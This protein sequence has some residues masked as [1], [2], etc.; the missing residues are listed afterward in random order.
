M[1][2]VLPYMHEREGKQSYQ[3]GKKRVSIIEANKWYP[4][5][6]SMQSSEG[7]NQWTNLESRN[8]ASGL[9]LVFELTSLFGCFFLLSSAFAFCA[10]SAVFP[11]VNIRDDNSWSSFTDDSFELQRFK[12]NLILQLHFRTWDIE[13]PIFHYILHL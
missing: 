6:W 8:L 10:V 11:L 1:L 4:F 7:T 2:Q 5:R 13:E 3:S 9:K 12:S